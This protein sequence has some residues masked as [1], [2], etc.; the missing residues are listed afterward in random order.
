MVNHHQHLNIHVCMCID[1]MTSY[2]LCIDIFGFMYAFC[3]CIL[4][5]LITYSAVLFFSS[6]QVKVRGRGYDIMC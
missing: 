1:F 5:V 4:V 3:A 6:G 2:V